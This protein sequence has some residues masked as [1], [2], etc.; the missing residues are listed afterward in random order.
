MPSRPNK[1]TKQKKVIYQTFTSSN[2]NFQYYNKI[3]FSAAKHQNDQSITEFAAN[4]GLM[5]GSASMLPLGATVMA[6]TKRSSAFAMN[7]PVPVRFALVALPAMYV[8]HMVNGNAQQNHM[9]QRITA[10]K[11]D[12]IRRP[13]VPHANVR[14]EV[15]QFYLKEK[16]NESIDVVPQ[17]NIRH[18][19]T[20]SMS[21]KP[22]YI[23]EEDSKERMAVLTKTRESMMKKL[24]D[25]TEG[26][27]AIRNN[28]V[29]VV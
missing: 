6:L 16:D 22:M 12:S 1:L 21:R 9:A 25:H 17:L 28:K 10:L 24:K 26:F 5:Y 4:K 18:R 29:E 20:N 19:M 3:M 15:T 7:V 23:T 8:S 13:V 14:D 27:E 2:L 11:R